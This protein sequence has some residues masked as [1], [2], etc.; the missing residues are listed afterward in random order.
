MVYVI[1]AEGFEE[2]EAVAPVDML[3][4]AGVEVKL[5]G[6]AGGLVRS[7][8]GVGIAADIALCE[9]EVKDAEMI[10]LPGGTPGTDN[11]M[12]NEK[13]VDFIKDCYTAGAF[14]AS[15]CAAPSIPGR[16]GMLSG[17]HAVCY[18]G[19]EKYLQG[20]KL[21]ADESVVRDGKIIT[22]RGAGVSLEFGLKLVEAL[23]GFE[24]AEKIMD[25]I[26]YISHEHR[27]T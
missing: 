4:R 16:L 17:K 19:Y 8:R 10:F 5:V 15:I 9:T 25:S 13:A 26:R 7:T 18:P 23:K 20:A 6:L 22:G 24:A 21:C 1:L 14:I 27:L 3:R 2:T 12:K 11:I